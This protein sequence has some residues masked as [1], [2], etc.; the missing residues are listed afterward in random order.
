MRHGVKLPRQ[1]AGDDVVRAHV[2]WWR[3]IGFTGGRSDQQEVLEDLAGRVR[4][5]ASDLLL[6]APKPFA[7]IDDAVLAELDDG[8]ASRG[9]NLLQIV[10]DAEDEPRSE[11]RRVGR[12]CI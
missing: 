6:V 9:I 2:A 3:E 11:E 10:V 4:L 8:L 12:A 1:L 7:Q 5:D